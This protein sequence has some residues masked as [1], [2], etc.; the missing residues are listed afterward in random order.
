MPGAPFREGETVALYTIERED[1]EFIG[2]L[3]NDPEIRHGVTFTRPESDVDLETWFEEHVSDTDMDDEGAQFMIVPHEEPAD[4][5]GTDG[6]T[7]G[8][9]AAG[10]DAPDAA[11]TGVTDADEDESDG[12]S[13]RAVGYA[14]LFDVQRPA[15]HGE[16][17]VTVAPEYRNRGYATDA[18]RELV[19]YGI[20]ELR[21]TKVRARALVTNDASRAVLENVGFRVGETRR[22]AKRVDGEH[23][24]V[25]AYSLLAEDWFDRPDTTRGI[26]DRPPG[27]TA[28]ERGHTDPFA[29]DAEGPADAG[30]GADAD[31]DHGGER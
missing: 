18:L 24:D 16:V 6:G 27:A 19:A 31:A 2:R 1:L 26:P 17:S 29:T 10:L 21:L 15:G 13:P 11:E 30:D 4:R 28:A 14:S 8:D 22:E 20:E 3:R 7:V 9:D 5:V 12:S 25:V 23:V